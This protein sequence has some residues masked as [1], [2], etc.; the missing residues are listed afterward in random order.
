MDAGSRGAVVLDCGGG[1]IKA[2]F[3]GDNEPGAAYEAVVGRPKYPR[4]LAGGALEGDLYVACGGRGG[5]PIAAA[6]HR[7]PP[8][9]STAGS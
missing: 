1:V 9:P 3:A 7:P 6:P 2:G 4:V 8:Q 5:V